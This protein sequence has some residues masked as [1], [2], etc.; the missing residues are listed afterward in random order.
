MNASAVVLIVEDD[1]GMRQAL[2]GFVQ[3][4]FPQ[5]V[6]LQAADGAHALAICQLARPQLVLMDV[7]LPDANG[8]ELIPRI[9]Q[10]L[11]ECATIVVSQYTATAYLERARAAGAFAYIAKDKVFRELLP[12]IGQ[13]LNGVQSAA[14]TEIP[15]SRG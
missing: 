8:I 7:G 1:A 9:R 12:L 4:G 2:A 13:V 6:V 5:L 15:Q 10:A 3:S 11:S 14:E